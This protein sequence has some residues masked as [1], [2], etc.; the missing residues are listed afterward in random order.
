MSTETD[1]EQAIAEFAVW[2]IRRHSELAPDA[3]F[4]VMRELLPLQ[5]EYERI[6]GRPIPKKTLITILL[7]GAFGEHPSNPGWFLHI[8]AHGMPAYVRK[9]IEHLGVELTPM[10]V[11]DLAAV[12][13]WQM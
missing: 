1:S 12:P 13:C 11:A 8:M 7:R 2:C 4:F 6:F 9:V 10:S 5:D 3:D